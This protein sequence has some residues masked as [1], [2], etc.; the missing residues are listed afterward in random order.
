MEHLINVGYISV[1]EEM[2][3]RLINNIVKENQ[4]GKDSDADNLE[5]I[6]YKYSIQKNKELLGRIGE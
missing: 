4:N 1:N 2:I 6:F 5:E 3:E